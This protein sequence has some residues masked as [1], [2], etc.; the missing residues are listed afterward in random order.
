[1]R[2][3]TTHGHRLFVRC[4]LL[5]AKFRLVGFGPFTEVL[6][7][8]R[9]NGTLKK[10]QRTVPLA[11]CIA[12]KCLVKLCLSL[13]LAHDMRMPILFYLFK[14]RRGY[15]RK[16][17][18]ATF[19]G[20]LCSK[21]LHFFACLQAGSLLVRAMRASTYCAVPMCCQAELVIFYAMRDRGN[22]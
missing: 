13:A 16:P 18:L 2:A 17:A 19:T 1:M 15:F 4:F 3:L 14:K 12:W 22:Q 10:S 6:Q 9:L 20:A 7:L 5:Q 21:V 11:P 8:K